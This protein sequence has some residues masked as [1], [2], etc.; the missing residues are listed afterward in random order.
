MS[1]SMCGSMDIAMGQ[2]LDIA[3]G[4]VI[5]MVI[6]LAGHVLIIDHY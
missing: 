6:Q 5:G 3:I 2:V 4:M 1:D